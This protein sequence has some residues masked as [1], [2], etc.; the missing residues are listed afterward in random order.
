MENT[1]IKTLQKNANFGYTENGAKTR[2]ST[3][4]TLYD[5]F[6][7]GGAYRYRTDEDCI[8]LFKK[9]F[10]ENPFLSI[11][12]LFYIRDITDGQGER[13]FFRV[14]Y[15]W[16][17]KEHPDVAIR[18]MEYIP[19]FGTWKDLFDIFCDTS[20]EEAAFALVRNQLAK[21][22]TE[23]YPSLCAKWCPSY[24]TSSKKTKR[25]A[26]NFIKFMGI[27]ERRYRKILSLLRERINVLERLLSAKEW[28]KIDFSKVPSVAGLKYAHLFQTRPELAK[29]YWE[30]ISNKNTK[31]NT[32]ALYPYQVVNKALDYRISNDI[33]EKYW[34]NLPDYIQNADEKIICVVDTSASMRWSAGSAKPIEV[35]I[36]LGMYCAER[37]GGTFH[38]KYISFSSHPQFIEIEGV[39]FKDKVKRIY[40]KNLCENTNIHATFDLL[41]EACLKSKE[42]DRPTKIIIISDMEMDEGCF[43]Y[44]TYEDAKTLMEN[45]REDWRQCGLEMP[46]LVYWNVNARHNNIL[47]DAKNTNVTYVSGYNTAIF[48]QI[49]EG[50]T[51][52]EVMYDK[53][54]SDRYKD[55]M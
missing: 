6:A 48:K 17:I 14:C 30:Y 4:K 22:L 31:V 42:E 47:D 7:F 8:L 33:V 25:K 3:E 38:N 21:D 45:I 46:S 13:R 39:N 50:K 36:S 2:L 20:L 27:S 52:M 26:R 44:E 43:N 51:G 37:L 16:L 11:K 55:I 41:K 5:L 29:R 28:D 23:E 1:F 24:N 18:N 19:A 15:Q 12:C 35:A 40:N 9:A 49:M 54:L 32:K 34:D 53:L 10:E